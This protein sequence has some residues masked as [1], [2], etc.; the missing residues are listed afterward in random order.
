MGI[1]SR[2]QESNISMVRTFIYNTAR[3]AILIGLAMS[4]FS[5]FGCLPRIFSSQQEP[6]FDEIAN[7]IVEAFE[8]DSIEPIK[9][10]LSQSA[11]ETDDL[12]KGITFGNELLGGYEVSNIEFRNKVEGDQF[13]K[14]QSDKYFKCSFILYNEIGEFR[15]YYQ[16]FTKNDIYPDDRGLYR[17][18]LATTETNKQGYEDRQKQL[19]SGDSTHWNYGATYERA[20]IYNPEWQTTPPPEDYEG[21]KY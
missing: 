20:G 16:Y 9:G 17:I 2:E 7:R 3:F 1:R 4:L 13:Q 15:L 11:L 6:D 21:Q 8:Q 14:G 18:Y 5:L 12:Q 10:I 19:K